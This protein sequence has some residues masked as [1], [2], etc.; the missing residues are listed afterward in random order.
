MFRDETGLAVTP[1]I[2]GDA[3]GR[4]T[5]MT[6]PIVQGESGLSVIKAQL[7]LTS[8]GYFLDVDGC[9]GS[10]TRDELVAFQISA[11]IDPSGALDEVTWERLVEG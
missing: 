5:L 2:D 11:V 9:F 3:N 10:N 4:Q 1:D 6:L 7:A 8:R